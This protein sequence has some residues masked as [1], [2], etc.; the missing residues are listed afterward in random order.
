MRTCEDCA[1]TGQCDLCQGYGTTPDSHPGAD[2]GTDC[3]A[4]GATG[5]CPTCPTDRLDQ[6]A[7]PSCV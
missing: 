1:D 2:D 4:C 3:P 5:A 6:E 7:S